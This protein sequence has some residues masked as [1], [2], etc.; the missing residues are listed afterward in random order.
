M[1]NRGIDVKELVNS[2]LFYPTIWTKHQLFSSE[3]EPV[4]IPYNNEV[5]DI[6]FEDPYKLFDGDLT[7]EPDEKRNDLIAVQDLED[8]TEQFEM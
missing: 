3:K 6:E 5:D 4:R 8:A 1:I 7:K 2:Q